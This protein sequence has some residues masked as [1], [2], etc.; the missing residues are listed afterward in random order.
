MPELL[1]ELLSEEIPARMQ[2]QAAEDLKRLVCKG[3]DDAN[4]TYGRAQAFV[5]PRRLSLVIDGL[6]SAQPDATEERRGP[7]VDAPDKAIEGFLKSAGVGRDAL[8]ERDTPKGKFFFITVNRQGAQTKA[9]LIQRILVPT[10]SGIGWP[11]SMRWNGNQFLYARPLHSLLAIFNGEPL[12]CFVGLGSKWGHLYSHPEMSSSG[13]DCLAAGAETRGHRF[14]APEPFSVTGFADYRDKLREA[15]VILDREERKEVILKRAR[16]LAV[17]EGLTLREDSGLLEEVAGLVEWPVVLMGQIDAAF[18]DVPPEVLITSM[19]AHQKYFALEDRDGRLAPRFIVVA[20]TETTDGGKQ[21]VA[22]NERVLRARLSDAEF[23]WNQD[24]KQPLESRVARLGQRIFHAKLGTDLDRAGRLARLA[25]T[26]ARYAG[27]DADLAERAGR[28]CK[29]DLTTGMVGEFPE[30][31]GIMGRYYALHDGE[32][33]EVADAIGAHYAPQ[34]PSDRCPT[35]PVGVAVALADKIDTLVG[36]FGINEKPTGS[37]DPFALRRAALGAI[38]LIVDNGLRCPLLTVFD[39]AARPYREAALAAGRDS[40]DTEESIAVSGFAAQARP[41]WSEPH[42]TAS[43]DLLDFFAERLKQHLRDRGVR[44]DLISAV[45]AR[46]G[47]DDLVRLLARVDALRDFLNSDDGAN[48]LTAFKRASNIVRIEEKKDRTSYDGEAEEN[49]FS[50]AE[51]KGLHIA[52]GRVHERIA[53]LL[54]D[55]RFGDAMSV[56]AELRAPV[57]AFFDTVTVNCE[58]ADLR[59]NRLR[60]LSQIRSALTEVADFSEIEGQGTTQ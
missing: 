27:A 40:G 52:L 60:L 54:A 28:L 6:P 21:V 36:F 43:W 53:P 8:E 13:E 50:Q 15:F 7:R 35:A 18:M 25:R 22:G 2:A 49:R 33:P 48:L 57:D 9:C 47:E 10:I 55:E 4:L 23:F 34:G 38:R 29:A 44:H 1:L 51:E 5:T 45:F 59:V 20:G 26:V 17:A 56:L 37:K 14:L 30:L 19:R 11:K 3:L 24:R 41:G 46:G 32:A 58:D 39:E 12:G 42:E 31:Q 16:T